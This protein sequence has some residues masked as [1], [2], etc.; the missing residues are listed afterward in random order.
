M[1]DFIDRTE[2]K[3][4]YRQFQYNTLCIVYHNIG[5]GLI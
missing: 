4:I 2:R 5:F 3:V 1:L